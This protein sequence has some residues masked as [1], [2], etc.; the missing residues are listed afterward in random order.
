MRIDL[1]SEIIR[2]INK[3]TL[4]TSKNDDEY[5]GWLF[6]FTSIYGQ[7]Y[8]GSQY[9]PSNQSRNRMRNESLRTYSKLF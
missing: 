5:Y 4:L 6:R 1:N 7:I 9:D 3:K 8:Y 2:L